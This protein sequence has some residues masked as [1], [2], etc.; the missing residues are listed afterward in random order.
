MSVEYII[1]GGVTA[2]QGA[3][4]TRERD[5]AVDV[6]RLQVGSLIVLVSLT[7]G[8]LHNHDVGVYSPQGVGT[9]LRPIMI[10]GNL[11]RGTMTAV[12]LP[13][14]SCS[15]TTARPSLSITWPSCSTRF[16]T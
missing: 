10:I 3:V 14:S 2:D 6:W 12:V 16:P 1:L 5:A 11:C 4:I 7:M 13:T 9:W 15:S 8:E